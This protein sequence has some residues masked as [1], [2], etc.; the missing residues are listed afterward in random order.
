MLAQANDTDI[1]LPQK[2]S[3]STE[4][5]RLLANQCDPTAAEHGCQHANR[6]CL[7]WHRSACTTKAI[8]ARCHTRRSHRGPDVGIQD[9]DQHQKHED[10]STSPAFRIDRLKAIP[11][12]KNRIHYLDTFWDHPF[13]G[14]LRPLY[15]D[16]WVCASTTRE[17]L[18]TEASAECIE[19]RSEARFVTC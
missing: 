14:L 1:K 16:L 5:A 17:A 6:A 3:T 9:Q 7:A 15:G 10:P 11:E 2:H 19:A 13:G 8:I 12:H 4:V 18:P